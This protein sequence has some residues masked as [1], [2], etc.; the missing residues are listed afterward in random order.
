[1][2]SHA[3]YTMVRR[4]TTYVKYLMYLAKNQV[5]SWWQCGVLAFVTDSDVR[6]KIAI[7]RAAMGDPQCENHQ[8]RVFDRIDDPVVA[9]PDP[10]QV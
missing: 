2:G 5:A 7:N 3:V 1:M 4:C 8:L 6:S 9:D 10:P